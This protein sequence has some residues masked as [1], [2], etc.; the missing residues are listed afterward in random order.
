M[1]PERQLTFNDD[2]TLD[3]SQLEGLPQDFIDRVTAP[4]FVAQARKQI[5]LARAKD[6]AKAQM[7]QR[8]KDERAEQQ[9]RSILRRPPG[10]SGRQRKRLR[11]AV[12]SAMKAERGRLQNEVSL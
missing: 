5:A 4:E 6:L 8:A 12:R 11:R 10:V 2:G 1:Q 9:A 7:E 3:P